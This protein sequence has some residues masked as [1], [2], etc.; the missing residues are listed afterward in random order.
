MFYLQTGWYLMKLWVDGLNRFL[1]AESTFSRNVIQTFRKLF[2]DDKEI[3][4]EGVFG[5]F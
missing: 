2:V 3:D 1:R 5:F 4:L